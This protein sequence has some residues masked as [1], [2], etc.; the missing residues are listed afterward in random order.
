MGRLQNGS[1]QIR[2][3]KNRERTREKSDAHPC[4]LPTNGTGTQEGDGPS[5]VSVVPAGAC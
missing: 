5:D 2:G 4:P 1:L 3:G